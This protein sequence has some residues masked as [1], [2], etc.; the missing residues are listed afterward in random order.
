M[1]CVVAVVVVA[2]VTGQ[3]VNQDHAVALYRLANG[4]D[5]T[6]G[7]KGRH[8]PLNVA[9]RVVYRRLDEWTVVLHVQDAE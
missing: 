3:P 8:I 6:H 1:E 9:P 4:N 5:G 7:R 2:A